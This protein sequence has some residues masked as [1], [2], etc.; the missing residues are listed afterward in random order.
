MHDAAILINRQAAHACSSYTNVSVLLLG[1]QDDPAAVENIR[2]LQQVFVT[3]YHFHTQTWQIPTVANPTA[4]LGMQMASFLEHARPN[5]LLIIY[6]SG[7]GYVGPDGQL[8][9]AWYVTLVTTLV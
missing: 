4:K 7:H 5:Q 8:Y 6:Y 1:W 9:W 3:D 2:A